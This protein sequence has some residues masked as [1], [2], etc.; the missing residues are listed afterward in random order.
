MRYWYDMV[1]TSCTTIL[2]PTPTKTL[3]LRSLALARTARS[4]GESEL[5]VLIGKLSLR[6]RSHI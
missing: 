3:L 6:A 4:A 1:L 2:E 5:R